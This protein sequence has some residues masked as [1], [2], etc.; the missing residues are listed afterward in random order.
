[1]QAIQTKFISP[2]NHRGSRIKA[3]CAA[4]TLTVQWDYS[5]GIDGN[6]TAAAIALIAKLDWQDVVDTIHSG[7]L[8]DGSMVHVLGGKQ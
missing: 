1:M 4:G 5:L 2:T 3:T 6:H 8:K 7:T